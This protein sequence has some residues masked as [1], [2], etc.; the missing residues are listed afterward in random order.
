MYTDICT[1]QIEYVFDTSTKARL[2]KEFDEYLN[3]RESVPHTL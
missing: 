1:A 2:H 3:A